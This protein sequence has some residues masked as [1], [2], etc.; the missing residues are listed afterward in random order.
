MAEHEIDRLDK[1][2]AKKG[3]NDNKFKELTG[4]SNGWLGKVR[5]G[6]SS[7]TDKTRIPILKA[8]PDLNESWLKSGVGSML[9]EDQSQPG[10]DQSQP[11]FYKIEKDIF[12]LEKKHFALME[13]H[14]ITIE[15]KEALLQELNCLREELKKFRNP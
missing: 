14:I 5:K 4:T 15:Q 9:L 10:E 12:D 2:L 6:K 8:F 1:Y 3:I 11:A 13:K 7:I